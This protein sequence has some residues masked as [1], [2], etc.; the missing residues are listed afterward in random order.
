MI[1]KKHDCGT[2]GTFLL[3]W[4]LLPILKEFGR[5][6]LILFEPTDCDIYLTILSVC[7][8][9][10]ICLC[11]VSQLLLLYALILDFPTKIYSNSVPWKEMYNTKCNALPMPSSVYRQFACGLECLLHLNNMNCNSVLNDVYMLWIFSTKCCFCVYL[12]Y[13]Y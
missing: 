4:P 9:I 5:R 8:I 10:E 11:L 7:W 2:L 13:G 12:V 6:A 1:K 3:F